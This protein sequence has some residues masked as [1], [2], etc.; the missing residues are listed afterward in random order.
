MKRIFFILLFFALIFPTFVFASLSERLSGRIL[1]QVE[2]KG[3][4]WYVFPSDNKRYFLG[5]PE[6]A[7]DLMRNLGIGIS[8][9]NLAKIPVALSNLS[10]M[11]LQRT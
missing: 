5:R 2:E 9:E 7:F 11:Y 3:E 10:G 1:L 8:N 4:A 6:D